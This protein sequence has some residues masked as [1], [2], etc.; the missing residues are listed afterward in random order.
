MKHPY[1]LLYLSLLLL[2]FIVAPF[3]TQA[4]TPGLIYKSATSGGNKI[5]DPNGDGYVSAPRTPAGFAG[6]RDEGPGFSEITY[7]PFPALSNEVLGDLTTGTSGG[8]T[9]LAPPNYTGSTGS[10]ISAYYNG[11]HVMFRVRL[12]GSSTSSKGYSVLIDSNKDFYNPS[13]G[14]A[15]TSTINPDFEYEV[16]F[17]SN[18]DVAVYDHR[19]VV[20]GGPKIWSGSAD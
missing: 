16:V 14:Q 8:H 4:Q 20:N 1:K 5:L 19:T 12:G 7:R 2:F 9:D 10:P 3:V 15:P 18:F 17:A 6:T 13:S 11:T